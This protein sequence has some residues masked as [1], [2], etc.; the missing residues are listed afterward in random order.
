MKKVLF[1]LVVLSVLFVSCATV[2]ETN[3][4]KEVT[5]EPVTETVETPEVIVEPEPAS[6]A[7]K[8]PVSGNKRTHIVETSEP[9]P[10]NVFK[11]LSL[12]IFQNGEKLELPSE[13]S[14]AFFC[15]VFVYTEDEA[16]ISIPDADLLM[17][18]RYY[19]E[20]DKLEVVFDSFPFIIPVP[21]MEV[22]K[23]PIF[24]IHTYFD[25]DSKGR[26][27][28]VTANLNGDTFTMVFVSKQ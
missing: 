11:L 12:G 2:S 18:V 21:L 10:L 19:L 7:V 26:F 22:I 6:K 1:I 3:V 27:H 5:V 28:S 15:D 9:E 23:L 14:G 16:T 13:M 25:I 8:G 24:P 4:T 20:G 17:P